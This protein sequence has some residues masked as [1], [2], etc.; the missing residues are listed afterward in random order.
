VIALKENEEYSW[1]GENKN[2]LCPWR[3]YACG[4]GFF[5]FLSSYLKHIITHNHWDIWYNLWK[6]DDFWYIHL[7][8]FR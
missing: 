7:F 3:K 4:G 1:S 2:S 8:I 6:Y 5:Y